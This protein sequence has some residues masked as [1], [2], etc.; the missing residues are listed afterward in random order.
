MLIS[1]TIFGTIFSLSWVFLL[2]SHVRGG[3][4]V[5]VYAPDESCEAEVEREKEMPNFGAL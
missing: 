4:L 3:R 1:I 2:A 5:T